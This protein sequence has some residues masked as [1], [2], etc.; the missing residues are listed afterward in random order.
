MDK[1]NAISSKVYYSKT[2][3]SLTIQKNK[4]SF[5]RYKNRFV[6]KNGYFNEQKRKED[7]KWD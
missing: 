3:Q 7:L 5:L 2:N 1:P 4:V 6:R